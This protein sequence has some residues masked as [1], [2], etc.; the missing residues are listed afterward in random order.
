MKR[1]RK[2]VP[3]L[4]RRHEVAAIDASTHAPS[5]IQTFHGIYKFVSFSNEEPKI[6]IK[7]NKVRRLC[8]SFVSYPSSSFVVVQIQQTLNAHIVLLCVDKF[9]RKHHTIVDVLR[10]AAP[11]PFACFTSNIVVARTFGQ[12]ALG[13][14]T[15]HRPC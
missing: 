13:A 2:V 4:R 5:T 8:D 1:H 15:R 7:F 9:P 10:A 6:K 11:L 3:T 12:F 14:G